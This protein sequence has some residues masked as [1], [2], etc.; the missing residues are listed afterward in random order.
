MGGAADEAIR[1]NGGIG[2]ARPLSSPS[3]CARF[4]TSMNGGD[5]YPSTGLV[6]AMSPPDL[7]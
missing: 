5:L 7:Y 4:A 2:I 1:A 3:V 6:S